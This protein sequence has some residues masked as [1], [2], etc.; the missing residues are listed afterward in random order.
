[1]PSNKGRSRRVRI[2]ELRGLS[3]VLGRRPRGSGC[4]IQGS[5]LHLH[6]LARSA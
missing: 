6:L 4:P 2:M 1:M 3:P 5:Y